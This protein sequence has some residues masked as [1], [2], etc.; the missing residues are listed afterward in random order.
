MCFYV[1]YMYMWSTDVQQAVTTFVPQESPPA[2]AGGA[3]KGQQ[4]KDSNKQKK[5]D[6]QAKQADSNK[7]KDKQGKQPD[8]KSGQP[9]SSLNKQP[10]SGQKQSVHKQ[11]SKDA[12]L[13]DK[14]GHSY[15]QDKRQSDAKEEQPQDKGKRSV[16]YNN[17]RT[18]QSPDHHHQRPQSPHRRRLQSP[19]D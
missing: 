15:P 13:S 18:S 2:K 5:A 8:S 17:R 3:K 16:R 6:K 9:K 14:S 11:G 4:Q 12:G 19:R 10:Q 1:L 7:A